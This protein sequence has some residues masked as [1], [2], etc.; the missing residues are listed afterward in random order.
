MLVRNDDREYHVFVAGT[1]D[2]CAVQYV[3]TGFLRR[4][5]YSYKFSG[6][7]R[8]ERNAEIFGLD[9]VDAFS[10]RETQARGL[11][12]V[13]GNGSWCKFPIRSANVHDG[14]LNRRIWC[15]DRRSGRDDSR[16]WR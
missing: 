14:L 6:F 2:D 13:Q 10:T 3:L 5:V 15:Y 16:S 4:H 8:R 7:H 9:A 11:A 12:D 1:A